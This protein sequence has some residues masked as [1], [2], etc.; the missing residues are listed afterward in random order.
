MS[1][2]PLVS[3]IIIFFNA[4]KFFEEAIESVFAQTYDNWELLLADD[5]ST[6]KSTD[7]ALKYARNH[8][9]K[10][11]YLEHDGHQNHGMSAT[12]NL[13]IRHAKGEYIAFLDSD[14]VWLPPK[15]E[16]Q[17]AIMQAY[18][19]A[20]MV[21]GRPLYW[22]SWTGNPEDSQE[23]ILA[24][25]SVPADNLYQPPI[26]FIQN[27]PLGKTGAPCPCDFLLRKEIVEKLG[28]FEEQFREIYQLYEDQ[29]FLA[30][31]YLHASVF[32]SS[33]CWDN[34]RLHPDSCSSRVSKAKK[35]QGV[36]LFFLKWLEKYLLDREITDPDV[37]QALRQA[38]WPYRHPILSRLI[39]LPQRVR[40]MVS[41]RSKR[42]AFL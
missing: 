30:K 13:G 31:L 20:G 34:Y 24:E 36:R 33:Q 3:C 42:N 14:D 22:K 27:H 23:D 6:D 9:E 29:G 8:P 35:Q 12:R 10:I 26:L 2:H 1:S 11:R 41:K 16:Q 7:I 38:L 19:E 4:E 15:L 32:V 28:G 17:V 37:W 21:Y 39:N 5:G 18:P 25:L 40:Q